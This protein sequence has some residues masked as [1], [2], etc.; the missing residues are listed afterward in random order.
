MIPI[1][2]YFVFDIYGIILGMAI[3]NFLG[4]LPILKNL[5]ITSFFELKNIY[6]VLVH[7]FGVSMGARLPSMV[8]K[9]AIAPLFGFFI[10]GIFYWFFNGVWLCCIG[11][12]FRIFIFTI[13]RW[14]KD[15]KNYI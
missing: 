1:V 9:L 3:S 2:L 15:E 6:K 8:D 13:I 5:K 4:S 7:N 11:L 12:L 14:L 10:V